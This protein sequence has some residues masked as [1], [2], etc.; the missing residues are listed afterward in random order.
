M[1]VLPNAWDAISARIVE[2]EG[3]PAVASS[4]AGCAAVL[5]YADGQRIP[6]A[7]MLMLVG[8]IAA[9]V[10]V[11]VTADVEA[12]YGDPV[13]TVR[14]LVDAGVV[15]L[16]FE[17]MAHDELLPLPQQLDRIR[18]VRGVSAMLVI[19]ART[20]IFLA[21]HG[22][23][24]TRFDRAVERL[25]AFLEAG[26]DCAFAPGVEDAETIARL[27]QSVRGP[28]NILAGPSTPALSILESLRVAR[29]SF[30]SGPS[31]VALGAFQRFVRELRRSGTFEALGSGTVPYAEVQKMLSE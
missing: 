4:S 22:D 18:A 3:F 25:N 2:A 11:P 19:N 28:L 17:D 26:A 24:A 8:R 10:D 31:R 16:N 23:P 14:A 27:V 12:G 6:A 21:S 5:G 30:G 15:G 13:E 20:D 1:L 29:V 9:S 7:E